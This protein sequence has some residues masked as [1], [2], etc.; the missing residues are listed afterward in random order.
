MRLL[1][2]T[3]YG[4]G[5]YRFNKELIES[6][7]SDG[8]EVMISFPEDE[9]R[10]KIEALGCHYIPT[11]LDRR[12][13]NLFRDV[14]LFLS[15]H[16]L[17]RSLLPDMVLTFTIKPNIYGGYACRLA[18]IPQVA[19]IT[20]L[21]TAMEHRGILQKLVLVLYRSAL[22]KARCVFF[23]N[24]ENRQYFI[25]HKLLQGKEAVLPGAGI[26]LEQFTPEEYP[27][28]EGGLKLLYLGRIMKEKGVEELLEAMKRVKELQPKIQLELVGFYEEDYAEQIRQGEAE[29]LLRFHGRQEEVRPY[30]KNAHAVILPSYHEGLSNVLLEAAATGR[31]VLASD[32]AG[33]RE[34][35]DEGI[36]G[37]G[38]VP[39]DAVSLEQAIVKF[40]ELPY[41][42][43]REM[44]LAGRRKMELEYNRERVIDAYRQI[45]YGE[46]PVQMNSGA[47]IRVLQIFASLDR[48]GA[49]TELMN[50][51]RQMDREKVQFDFVV[52]ESSR[53]Y[54]YEAEIMKLGGR[55]YHVPRFQGWN[56]K[57]SLRAWNLLL[58]EHPEWRIL[59]GNHT[60]CAFI[61]MKAA[62]KYHRSTIIH[63]HSASEIR[64]LKGL[65]KILLR[66][67]LR[68]QADYLFACSRGSAVWMF[69]RRDRDVRILKNAIDLPRYAFSEELRNKKREELGVTEKYVVGHIGNFTRPKN[70]PFLLKVFRKLKE[71]N[72]NAILLLIGKYDND[73]TIRKRIARM[74]LS[75][76]VILTGVR[77]DIPE[78]LQAMDVFVFPSLYEG[79]PVSLMEAQASGLRCL[80]SDT[81]S[82]EA[83]VTGLVEYIPLKKS[84][85]YWSEKAGS[86]ACGYDRS[87]PQEELRH[88]GYDVAVNAKWLEEFYLS[89]R[90]EGLL[91]SD[92]KQ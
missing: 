69:G 90:Q 39:R 66:L 47:P 87:S 34:T 45:L 15:Y 9:Y 38:F 62:R 10:E 79:I 17:L 2:L 73:P 81:V 23:Q 27:S 89:I 54:A 43:K 5:A 72:N 85:K 92:Q 52:N 60:S 86:Y 91:D 78:L 36:S 49:E 77:E 75:D 76:S 82:K 25:E 59:H 41:E 11:E 70:Y 21:G 51:Y 53:E 61:Y 57:R 28:E 67:P 6:L 68:F 32:I 26:N 30:L 31:P 48:G 50:L 20:G 64:S 24:Q 58:Q 55:I 35:F 12:G 8:N 14:R 71:K 4:M 65:I 80:V 13:T 33:C 29:G 1:I 44:G 22:K 37:I 74:K 63:S 83:K 56:Y 84:H 88:A 42:K 16:R 3:N 7:L 19:N 40:Y 18:G 46:G